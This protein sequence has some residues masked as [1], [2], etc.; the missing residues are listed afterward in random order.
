VK[1]QVYWEQA[2]IQ[3]RDELIIQVLTDD[4]ISYQYSTVKKINEMSMNPLPTPLVKMNYKDYES[5]GKI[6]YYDLSLQ[7]KIDPS[8]VRRIEVYGTFDYFI[9]YKLKML[10]IG[11]FNMAVDT[12]LGASKVIADGELTLELRRPVLIDS[13][14]RSIY[15]FDPF[16]SNNY[17]QFSIEQIVSDYNGRNEKLEYDY[18]AMV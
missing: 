15:Y 3:F 12:P 10:M 2:E 17:E 6:D 9:E 18:N 7:I 8:K 1:Q 14:T 5:D 16:N 13:T 11:M 4:G